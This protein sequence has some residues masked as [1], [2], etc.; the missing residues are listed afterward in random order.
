MLSGC[1][2]PHFPRPVI[3]ALYSVPSIR[4]GSAARCWQGEVVYTYRRGLCCCPFK[5]NWAISGPQSVERATGTDLPR[6]FHIYQTFQ[7]KS[8]QTWD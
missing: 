3:A 1:V 8:K 7:I 2:Y 6:F 4:D 5:T